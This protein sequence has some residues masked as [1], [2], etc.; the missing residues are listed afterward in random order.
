[1]T[2]SSRRLWISIALMGVAVVWG[3]TFIMV[4]DA[5]ASYPL[6]SFLSWRFAIAVVAFLAI[7]PKSLGR[8]SAGTLR[9]GV[10]AGALLT[11]GYVF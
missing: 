10:L 3:G 5:V 7:F 1:M 11:A 4:K 8:L 2:D 9:V 6:Y